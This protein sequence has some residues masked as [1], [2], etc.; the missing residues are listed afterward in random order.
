MLGLFKKKTICLFT[1]IYPNSKSPLEFIKTV[2]KLCD[3]EKCKFSIVT[4]SSK[5]KKIQF[6]VSN[7]SL[8]L[9]NHIVVTIGL[10]KELEY[11]DF[12]LKFDFK[13]SI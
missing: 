3:S 11:V 10:L 13:R 4:I 9:L 7:S 2:Q 1:V 6:S 8:E 12:K 5:K